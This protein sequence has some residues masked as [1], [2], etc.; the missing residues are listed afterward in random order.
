MSTI[1]NAASAAHVDI[2]HCVPRYPT[3][4]KERFENEVVSD[5][6]DG[7]TGRQEER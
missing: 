1:R 6:E 4:R 5:P 2:E 7:K 3:R